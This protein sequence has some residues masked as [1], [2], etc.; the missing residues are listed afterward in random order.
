MDCLSIEIPRNI[1][2]MQLP[3]PELI[4]FYRNY[5]ER[6]L[7]LDYEVNDYFLEFGK[8]ILQWNRDDKEIPV[9]ERKPIKLLFLSP[10]GDLDINWAMIDIIMSS[11]T[12]VYGYSMGATSSAAAYI[13][14]AC[15]KR[16][17]MP[18]SV[19]LLHKGSGQFGGTYEEVVLSVI[20][21]QRKIETLANFIMEHSAITKETLDENLSG[22]WYVPAQ[23]A[24]EL[25]FVEEIIKDI[26]EVL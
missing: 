9:G 22:E 20:E 8:Y 1:E 25:G 24:V 10:G 18:N 2:N 13:F 19:F 4:T 5:N 21:Y 23:E 6:V 15:R 12:P 11:K 3:S 17:A 14:M 7:W 16:F 26:D